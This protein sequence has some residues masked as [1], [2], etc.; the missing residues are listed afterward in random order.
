MTKKTP[1][2]E[3]M[4]DVLKKMLGT[5]PDPKQKKEAPKKKAR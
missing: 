2:P 5:P 4:D 1:K 3:S